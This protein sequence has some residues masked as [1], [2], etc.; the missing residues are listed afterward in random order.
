MATENSPLIEIVAGPNGSG[1]STF[2][3]SYIVRTRKSI[4]YLNPD[5]IA[6]G[7]SPIGV[8]Q[9]SFQAGRILIQ[10]VKDRIDRCESFAFESTL[11]GKTWLNFLKEAKKKGY[12]IRI[13]FLFLIN[14]QKNI[15]RIKSRVRMGGHNIPTET[16]K[17]RHPRCFE[18]F[19]NLYRPLC[20]EWH[21]FNNTNREPKELYSFESFG[22][23][24]HKE[25]SAFI[26]KFLKGKVK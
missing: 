23:L 25:Q 1:K 12:K 15:E 18:N 8:E 16:V 19:W 9:A 17:R 21:I 20:D 7:F 4:T 26:A 10:E 13:Y 5:I 14:V 22:K 6:S 2:A 24:S 3:E 11:S